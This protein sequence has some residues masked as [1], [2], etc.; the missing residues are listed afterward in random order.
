MKYLPCDWFGI[1]TEGLFSRSS[2]TQAAG[3]RA[4]A[5]SHVRS[6]VLKL[7]CNKVRERGEAVESL[8]KELSLPAI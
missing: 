3:H 6:F 5:G 1:L 2:S 8:A 7:K 4:T